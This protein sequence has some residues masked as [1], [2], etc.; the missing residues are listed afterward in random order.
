QLGRAGVAE[1]S[2]H[3]AIGLLDALP[4]GAAPDRDRR[5]A[6]ATAWDD[7]ALLLQAR[8]VKEAREAAGRA[9]RLR[10]GLG[11][12]H[13]DDREGR[14]RLAVGYNNCG[15][16]LQADGRHDDAA[17]AY[18]SARERFAALVKEFPLEMGGR[19]RKGLPEGEEEQHLRYQE[20][21]VQA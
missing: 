1:K 13:P 3:E 5:L 8:D 7:L 20:Q 10:A 15:N 9:L 17:R 14:Y 19:P 18:E 2:Y 11:K 4:A 21:L 6:L 12:D 16:L